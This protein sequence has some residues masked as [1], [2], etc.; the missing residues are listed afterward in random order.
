LQHGIH[1]RRWFEGVPNGDAHQPDN[2]GAIQPLRLRGLLAAS[3]LVRRVQAAAEAGV[4]AELTHDLVKSVE[5][6]LG[7]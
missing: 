1:N 7:E 2:F 5:A 6:R 3:A 4:A